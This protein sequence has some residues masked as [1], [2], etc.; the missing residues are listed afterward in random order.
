MFAYSGIQLEPPGWWSNK[1][2]EEY[3]KRSQ[4]VVDQFNQLVVKELPQKL[5]IDGELTLAENIADL[6]GNRLTYYSY[7][8]SF[9]Y[10]EPSCNIFA[11][12]SKKGASL[13]SF[14]HLY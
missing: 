8:K 14:Q 3:D 1:T 12:I 6:G 4:C 11:F 13:M 5:T 9:N 10:F 7:C 2:Y